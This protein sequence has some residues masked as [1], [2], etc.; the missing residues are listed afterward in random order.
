MKY[1]KGLHSIFVLLLC[2]SS[3]QDWAGEKYMATVAKECNYNVIG[4]S[5][6]PSEKPYVEIQYNK[7]DGNGNN[8]LVSEMVSPPFLF[9][10]HKVNILCDSIIS[11]WGHSNNHSKYKVDGYAL[12]IQHSY[13]ETDSEY[14][15]IINHSANKT[16][17][18][19]IAGSRDME[20]SDKDR[21]CN[22]LPLIKTMPAVYYR[23]A[24][25]YYLLFPDKKYTQNVQG[26]ASNCN[27]IFYFEG[28]KCGDLVLEKPW[29]VDEVMNLYRSEYRNS[30]DIRL[31]VEVNW[32]DLGRMTEIVNSGKPYIQFKRFYGTIMP[33][34][35]LRGNNS[36]PLLATPYALDTNNIYYST[37]S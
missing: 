19:F 8:V 7:D 6:P 17:E 15:R 32:G 18:F 35:E 36:L 13:G 14:L 26:D 31:D 12:V 28:N 22:G 20:T 5:G 30:P 11:I 3:C 10:G 33:G 9:G 24:P 23:H 4:I 34:E 1:F 27:D 37:Q 29:S 16:I 2:L 25:I 21:G